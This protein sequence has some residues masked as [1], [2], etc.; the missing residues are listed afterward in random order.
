MKSGVTAA[1]IVRHVS[2]EFV[3]SH[4]PC[5]AGGKNKRVKTAEEVPTQLYRR[6]EPL[7]E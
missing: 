1:Y 4:C 7:N 3:I 6:T 5:V 2:H